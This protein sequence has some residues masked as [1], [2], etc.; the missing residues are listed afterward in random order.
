MAKSQREWEPADEDTDDEPADGE[1]APSDKA[2]A[3]RE[4]PAWVK[5]FCDALV[6]RLPRISVAVVCRLLHCVTFPPFGRTPRSSPSRP[7]GC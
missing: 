4:V 1:P 2:P 6:A 7:A 3:K 5:R